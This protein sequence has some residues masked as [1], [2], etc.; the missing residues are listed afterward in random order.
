[1][2]QTPSPMQAVCV[3]CGSAAGREPTHAANAAALGRA[4]AE[5]RVTLVYGGGGGGL[6]GVAARAALAA[7]GRVVGVIPEFLRTPELALAQAE[8]VTVG[9]MHERK[10]EMFAHA[11]AFVVLPGGVGTLE[12]VV[13]LL[14]WARL[15]LHR[16]P[17]VFLNAGGY[18]TPLFELIAHTIDEGFTPQAF[19][20]LW[21]RV[22][23]VE[24]VLPRLLAMAEEAARSG[25]A[26]LDLI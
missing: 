8:L 9:S 19:R 4:L 13:E 15:N 16:K 3:F 10:A 18:W 20:S 2:S 6:M 25:V 5:A 14:S 24:E 23:R 11:D 22:E 26:P 17:I 7:G 1:M 12:E 21:T